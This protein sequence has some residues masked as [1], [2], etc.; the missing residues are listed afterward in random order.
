MRTKSLKKN[1]INVITL[2]VARTYMT[3]EVLMGQL[4]PAGRT[5]TMK[6]K[7]GCCGD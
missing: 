4:K 7:V 6:K 1:R 3:V 5:L 2:D